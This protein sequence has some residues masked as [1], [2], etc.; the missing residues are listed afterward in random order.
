[1][2]GTII[3]R[4]LAVLLLP[5][6]TRIL[7]IEQYG[8]AGTAGALSALLAIIYGL[9]LNFSIVRFYY[10]D[11]PDARR[12][13]WAALLRLQAGAALLLAALTFATGPLWSKLLG[14]V[15]WNS[16]LQIAVIVAMVT[17]VQGTVMSLVR[18]QQRPGAFLGLLLIQ[19][20]LGSGLGIL[21]ATK[22]GA[23]GYIG[24]LGI[25]SLVALAVGLAFTYRRPA[26][27]RS[28]LVTSLRV[29]LPALWHQMSVWGSNLGDRLIIA[30]YLGVTEVARYTIPYTAGTVLIL[31]LTS[32]Q[33]AWAPTYMSQGEA[34]RRLLPGR[35]IVPATITAGCAVALLVLAAPPLIDILAPESFGVETSLVAIVAMATLP[36]AAYFMAVISLIDQ[37]KT[38]RLATSS[39]LGAVVNVVANLIA[40]PV[41]GITAAAVTTVVAN[42]IMAVMV[43]LAA[44]RLLGTSLRLG[45]LSAVWVTGSVIAVGLSYLPEGW[46]WAPVRL[47]L[48]VLAIACLLL[49][50]RALRDA[51]S[52]ATDG[53]PLRVV[54]EAGS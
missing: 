7:G 47:A 2:A 20:V 25:G 48:G 38:G 29:S 11:P 8:L 51:F 4:G 39:G 32:A 3:Q 1:M 18:A 24:G 36:R 37:K 43:I 44:E 54:E 26:W 5:V 40:I 6:T 50:L 52:S 45:W 53:V 13:D 49:A 33:Q 42:V 28:L 21:F 23:A 9:G 41:F 15:G 27:R 30:A 10:D 31:L 16:A 17:A 12:T 35:L 19:L 46:S 22:W 34:A 14:D